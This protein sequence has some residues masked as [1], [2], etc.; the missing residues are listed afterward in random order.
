MYLER[1]LGDIVTELEYIY[2]PEE[3]D[4]NLLTSTQ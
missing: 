1:Y 3:D 2:K 4:V